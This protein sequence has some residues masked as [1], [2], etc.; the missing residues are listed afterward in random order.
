[1]DQME[2]SCVP[3][4]FRFHPTEEELVG[5]YLRRKINS[6][7]IDLDVIVDIDLYKIE[8]WDIQASCKLGY[9]E[10]NEWYFF[11]HKDKKYPTGTRTNRA[12]TAGFWKATGRDKAVLSKNRII[13]M[14]KTLVFYKGRA[15]NGRKTDWIMHEYRLQTSEQGPPQEEGWVVCRAFKKPS[16]NHRQ[17]FEAWAHAFY[18]RENSQVRQPSFPDHLTRTVHEDHHHQAVH[19]NEAPTFH[20]QP[21]IN[22]SS[23]LLHEQDH[24]DQLVYSHTLLENQVLNIDQ[25]PQLNSP[26]TVSASFAAAN[27][28]LLHNNSV[29]IEDFDEERSTAISSHYIDWRSLDDLLASQLS[30]TATTS[31]N[32]PNLPS[33]SQIMN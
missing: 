26:S 29:A 27:E 24:H 7:R 16:P 8:P 32:H 11:S 10:Q 15:P 33:I 19:P 18:F 1:M 17:G 23:V 3:P 25:L 13:G 4:G 28:G 14:R 20:H 6:L 30:S 5:Y 12:T 9:E 31:L 22:S 2:S 21:M